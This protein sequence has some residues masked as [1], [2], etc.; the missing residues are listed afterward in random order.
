MRQKTFQ[1]NSIKL[2][3]NSYH[4]SLLHPEP[5]KAPAPIN[6]MRQSSSLEAEFA[7]KIAK[8][9]AHKRRSTLAKDSGRPFEAEP[10]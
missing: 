3:R 7:E 4:L 8:T 2:R 5:T 1:W 6:I 9:A 10:Q